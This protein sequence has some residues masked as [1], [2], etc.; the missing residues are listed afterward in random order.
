MD[1]EHL[2]H[3]AIFKTLKAVLDSTWV[4]LQPL[5]SM[6]CLFPAISLLFWVG[7]QVAEW[8]ASWIKWK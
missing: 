2:G 5:Q 3:I 4:N 1:R 8:V 7:G 6:F